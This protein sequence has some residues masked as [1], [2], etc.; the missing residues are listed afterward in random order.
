MR[1]IAVA[2][3]SFYRK[4]LSPLKGKPTCRFCPTCSLYA[5]RVL[6]DWGFIRGSIMAVWRLLRCQPFCRG[7][8]D[9]PPPCRRAPDR[10][11]RNQTVPQPTR[12]LP[13]MPC[14]PTARES[15]QLHKTEQ[16]TENGG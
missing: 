15:R 4:F 9:F 16:R 11:F 7:G 14:D 3:I 13:F 6:R 10:I 5:I 8:Y 2:L 1:E 12:V